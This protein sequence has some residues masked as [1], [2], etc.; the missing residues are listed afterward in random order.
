MKANRWIGAPVVPAL[1]WVVLGALVLSL[2]GGCSNE[3]A[4]NP[5]APVDDA[6]TGKCPP[7]EWLREDG[8]CQ[9]AGPDAISEDVG[10]AFRI[11]STALNRPACIPR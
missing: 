1:G 5:V 9:P 11:A 7:G 10:K 4:S 2:L 6:C 3:S 8:C